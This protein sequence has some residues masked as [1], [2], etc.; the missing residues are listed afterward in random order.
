MLPRR[1]SQPTAPNRLPPPPGTCGSASRN[2]QDAAPRPH[3]HQHLPARIL[4]Q[5]QLGVCPGGDGRR[6]AAGALLV[7]CRLC[8]NAAAQLPPP[9]QHAAQQADLQASRGREVGKGVGGQEQSARPFQICQLPA[10]AQSPAQ[11]PTTHPVVHVIHL[12]AASPRQ[13]RGGRRHGHPRAIHITAVADTSSL[14]CR[15]CCCGGCCS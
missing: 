7:S 14:C 1:T 9:L 8:S 6:I 15:R 13:L 4:L 10:N 5:R 2:A 11:S 3:Q 12:A